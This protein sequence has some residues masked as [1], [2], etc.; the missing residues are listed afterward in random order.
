MIVELI[1]ITKTYPMG[2]SGFTALNL[3]L[4][5][6]QGEFLAVVG[7]SGSGK[8]TLMN[9]IGCLDKPTS[10]KYLLDGTDTS[11]KDDLELSR[12]R[13]KKI[14]FVFQSFNLLPRAT[15]CE[16][17]LLPLCYSK[18][19]ARH[20]RK[21]QAEEMLKR[22][23]L[24]AKINQPPTELSG[25]ERQRVAI[26][27]AL[28]NNPI[29]LCADEPT[30]NLDTTTGLEIMDIFSQLNRNGVTII[31]ITH[32]TDIASYASRVVRLRDG[33]IVE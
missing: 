7:H 8:S 16:N 15:A 6:E 5:I 10:G 26:A 23:G 22:V 19:I 27:R 24:S 11:Q 21:K 18:E 28:I 33:Q 30:G 4:S 31:L 2:K 14:G 1:D 9:I 20:Q 12:I 13:N 29:I 25:G 17:V 32:E 3:S